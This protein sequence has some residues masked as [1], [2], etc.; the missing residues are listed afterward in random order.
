MAAAQGK[1]VSWRK[2]RLH[3]STFSQKGADP[4]LA[5][6][7]SPL[8][9]LQE[10]ALSGVEEVATQHLRRAGEPDFEDEISKRGNLELWL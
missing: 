8:R 6:A 7:A 5:E 1:I 4:P 9:F 2:S 3:S 10:P